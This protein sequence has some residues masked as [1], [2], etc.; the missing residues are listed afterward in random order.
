M[1]DEKV[2]KVVEFSSSLQRR[3]L[4]AK[5]TKNEKKNLFFFCTQE[6]SWREEKK[7]LHAM[8]C[9]CCCYWCWCCCWCCCW[10]RCLVGVGVI[11]IVDDVVVKQSLFIVFHHMYTINGALHYGIQKHPDVFCNC[12]KRT[13]MGCQINKKSFWISLLAFYWRKRKGKKF[14]ASVL[15]SSYRFPFLT[16][17]HRD[18]LRTKNFYF[19]SLKKRLFFSLQ[20]IHWPKLMI[21]KKILIQS[22]VEKLIISPFSGDFFSCQCCSDFHYLR[23]MNNSYWMD[24]V[25]VL[26]EAAS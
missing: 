3:S 24:V 26:K 23:P 8:Q 11:L 12:K 22:D 15:E 20:T 14:K 19:L 4:E 9:C 5:L 1:G 16:T 10:W 25:D 21:K 18:P 13:N 7:I 6:G 17:S 2:F